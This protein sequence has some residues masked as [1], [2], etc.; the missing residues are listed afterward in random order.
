MVERQVEAA[1]DVGLYRM[2]VGTVV[3]DR[4]A[5]GMRRQLDRRAVLVGAAQKQDLMV[6]LPAKAGVD[7]GWQQ[8]SGEIAEMLYAVDVGQRAGDQELAH[9]TLRRVAWT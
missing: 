3:G 1:V 2:L 6:G 4:H 9:G 5:G 7:V 8:G